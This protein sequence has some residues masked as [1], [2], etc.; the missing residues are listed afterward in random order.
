MYWRLFTAQFRPSFCEVIHEG[1]SSNQNV[2]AA[3]SQDGIS[4]ARKNQQQG[5]TSEALTMF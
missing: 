4:K 2:A 5:T 1:L 3:T